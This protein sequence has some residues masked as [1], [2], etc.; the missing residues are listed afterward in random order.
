M[1]LGGVNIVLFLLRLIVAMLVG[2]QQNQGETEMII[3]I[4]V[5]ASLLCIQGIV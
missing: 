2:V 5:V 1:V 3:T 4:A